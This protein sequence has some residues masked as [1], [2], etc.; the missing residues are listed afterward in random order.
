M[1]STR[2]RWII[3]GA[4]SAGCVLANRLSA[5]GTRD[6][7]LLD[8]GPPLMPETVPAGL[9]SV[10]FLDAVN[11]PGRI[12]DAL[13]ARHTPTAEPRRYLRGRGVGGSSS[14]NAMVALRGAP[15]QYEDWGWGD[16]DAAW[17][18][19]ELATERAP[20]DRL[21]AVANALLN[22]DARAEV[23]TLTWRDGVRVTS[24]EAYLWPALGRPNLAVRSHCEVRHVIVVAN[25]ATGVELNSGERLEAD[26][27]ILAAGA[28][29]SPAV[30][31]RS[32]VTTPGLGHGLQDH[33]SAVFTLALRAGLHD[34]SQV[35]VS[36]HL[37]ATV[38][39]CGNVVQALPMNHVGRE[40]DAAGLGALLIA[41]MTP[42]GAQGH[43][44][45]DAEGEPIINFALLE[46]DADLRAMTLGVRL[47]LD[48]LQTGSFSEI[49]QSAFID[50][51]GTTIDALDSDDAIQ[52]WLRVACG[53]YVHA[54]STCAMG[55]VVDDD[56]AVLGYED[57]FVCDASVFPSIPHANT[58]LPTTM[59]AERLSP[60]ILQR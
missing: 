32:H 4:G 21:G 12:H 30:L 1:A 50:D 8:D 46:N 24:A 16:C 22:A 40:T 53:D 20:V 36:T 17:A 35:A 43:V 14:V 59:L 26:R 39:D 15:S 60:R 29:H 23:A 51:A 9:R 48:L 19:L 57:L 5:D 37:H 2:P 58:H 7:V 11:E 33:P 52:R 3:V 45:I 13:L 56:G 6:I 44:T 42:R 10:S 54:T 31:L 27:V 28:I 41:L 38:D 34:P 25:R 49:M 55:R 47:G 18:K